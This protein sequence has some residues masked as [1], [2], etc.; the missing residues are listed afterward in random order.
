MAGAVLDAR[1]KARRPVV[2]AGVV[3]V[4]GLYVA[5]TRGARLPPVR[6]LILLG[7]LHLGLTHTRY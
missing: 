6:L 3:L 5:L 2:S 1:A 7:L 4:A